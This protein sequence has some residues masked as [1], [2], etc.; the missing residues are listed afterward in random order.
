MPPSHPPLPLICMTD[1]GMCIYKFNCVI[2]SHTFITVVYAAARLK[3]IQ[4]TATA[5]RQS[6]AETKHQ[7]NST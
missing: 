3:L 7:A 1:D 6:L 4:L 2:D 5:C